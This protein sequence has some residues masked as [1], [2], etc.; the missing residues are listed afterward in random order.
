[1][2]AA[3]CPVCGSAHAASCAGQPPSTSVPVDGAV[4]QVTY[5]GMGDTVKVYDVEQDG[6]MVRLKLSD[7]DAKR[8]GVLKESAPTPA[9]EKARTAPANKAR[10][11][12]SVKA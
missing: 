12:R 1:M 3:R 5:E 11:A 7:Q 10:T 4:T 6:R 8:L 2:A 9:S